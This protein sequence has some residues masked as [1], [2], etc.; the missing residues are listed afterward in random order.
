MKK[1]IIVI[2]ITLCFQGF[3]QQK[4]ILNKPQVDKRVELLSIVFRLAERPEYSSNNFKLYTDKI[5]EHFG[6]FKNHELIMFTKSIIE[7]SGISWDSPM[8]M[9]VHL[10]DN[11][12]LNKDV[13]NNSLDTRW[14]KENADKFVLLLKKFYQDTQ[15]EI[16]FKGN[17]DLYLEAN[18]RF[19]SINDQVDLA[20]YSKFFGKDPTDKFIIINALAN[21]SSNYGQSVNYSDGHREV[22]ATMGAWSVD[23]LGMVIFPMNQYFPVLIHEFSHSF[24]NDLTAQNEEAL[25]NI[26]EQM[27]AMLKDKINGPYNT[28]ETMMNEALVRAAVIKYIK[29]HNFEKE[30]IEYLVAYELSNGFLWIRELVGELEKYDTQ[31][32]LYPTLESYMPNIIEAYKVYAKNIIEAE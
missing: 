27:Y 26:G 19:M 28:W 6:K 13:T 23:S 10:D 21:G 4:S 5:D 20:W 31:R 18:N 16:F 1:G 17:A 8:S 15:F 22:Y 11:L 2:L 29:D 3:A 14:S 25:K 32:D 12:N 24:V 30:V 9:A 7:E